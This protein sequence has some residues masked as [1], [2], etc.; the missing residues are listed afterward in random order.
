MN[1]RMRFV[2][3]ALA[4]LLLT[5]SLQL[6]AAT[7]D[8]PAVR[9][10]M[11]LEYVDGFLFAPAAGG[12]MVVDLAAGNSVVARSIVP[13]N[14]KVTPGQSD[15]QGAARSWHYALGGLGVTLDAALGQ[16]TMPELVVGGLTFPSANVRVSEAL[17]KVADRAVV[18]ILGADLLRRADVVVLQFK[19]ASGKPRL[20]LK[21]K[22][23]PMKGTIELPIVVKNNVPFVR[24]TLNGRELHFL[25]DT[26]SPE[27]FLS[28]EALR[29]SA[30]SARPGSMR[31]VTALDGASRKVSA[32]M[33][34]TLALG[35]REFS[36]VSFNIGTLPVFGQFT[37]NQNP[38]LLG[39]DILEQL[40]A[41][42]I[43]FEAGVI[44]L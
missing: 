36:S 35:S 29:A 31:T 12:W 4:A 44:R 8:A 13:A 14:V 24:G 23:T 30:L 33:P 42:E 43:D 7:P 26:G 19:G 28:L 39:N 38:A 16:V 9:G 1:M 18:G 34:A 32:T 40:G 22:G 5:C 3:P 6:S 11:Q 20:M 41:F 27:S 17:P 2:A 37:E 15:L 10:E 25:L 21:S